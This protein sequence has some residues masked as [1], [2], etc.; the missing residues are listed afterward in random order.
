MESLPRSTIR[1]IFNYL[2]NTDMYNVL[3]RLIVKLHSI[4]FGEAIGETI[5][6]RIVSIRDKEIIIDGAWSVANQRLV[7]GALKSVAEY[8][9][10]LIGEV[11]F[12][13]LGRLSIDGGELHEQ[14]NSTSS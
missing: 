10:F 12:P 6:Y 3:G 5:P 7:L 8:H 13:D 11:R 14:S 9:Q 4:P 1:L 2:F